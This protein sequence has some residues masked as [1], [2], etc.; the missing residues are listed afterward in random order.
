MRCP[1]H[2]ARGKS[3]PGAQT[4]PMG[5]SGSTA[6]TF[7]E[8]RSACATTYLICAH[9]PRFRLRVIG[10]PGGSLFGSRKF[11]SKYQLRV[12]A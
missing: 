11:T 12:G 1:R 8:Q 5:T 9:W 4:S 10:V 2:E 7:S 3:L 6:Q